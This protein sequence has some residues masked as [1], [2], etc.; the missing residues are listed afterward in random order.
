[1]NQKNISGV[2]NIYKIEALFKNSE[3][4]LFTIEIQNWIYALNLVGVCSS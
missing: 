1:M 4:F 2:G 3:Y